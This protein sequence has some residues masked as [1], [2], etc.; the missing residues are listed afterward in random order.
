MTD[1]GQ[2]DPVGGRLSV[3]SR[4]IGR[5]KLAATRLFLHWRLHDSSSSRC[6]VFNKYA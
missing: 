5:H 3:A 1:S 4:H 2:T 6:D